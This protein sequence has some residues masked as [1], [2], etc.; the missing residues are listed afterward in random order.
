MNRLRVAPILV[1]CLVV[2]AGCGS[3]KS[4]S[5][6]STSSSS[7]TSA[8]TTASA[9]GGEASKP[10]KQLLEDAAAALRNAHGYA[11]QGAITQNHQRLALK[12]ATTSPT[13]VHLT[14][15]MGSGTADL[16]G[17]PNASFI[18]GNKEFWVSQAGAKAARLAGH[19]IKVPA[20]NAKALTGSLGEFAPGTLA[21]CLV[22]NHGTLTI[23]GKTTVAGQPAILIR[24]AGNVPGST[25]GE[26]AIATTGAPYPLQLT[27]NG[28]QRPG[29]HVDVCNNGKGSSAAGTITFGEY[30]KVPPIQAP[31]DAQPAA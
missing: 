29:G 14:F 9:T 13:A 18:R 23:A 5:S 2:I 7:T 26:L 10:P 30:G 1:A 12:L 16:I 3:S 11:M 19:W 17:L 22:E 8:T 24:D 15:S 21:R 6:S 25:P 28:D 20:S 4:S 31:K 27:T